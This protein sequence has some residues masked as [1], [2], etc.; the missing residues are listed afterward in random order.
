MPVTALSVSLEA[1]GFTVSLG[2]W[3]KMRWEKTGRKYTK[4]VRVELSAQAVSSF[5]IIF[6]TFQIL[7]NKHDKSEHRRHRR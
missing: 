3:K 2:K 5:F 6:A 4:M 7:S 1:L